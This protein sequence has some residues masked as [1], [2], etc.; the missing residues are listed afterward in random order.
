MGLSHLILNTLEFL[1][2]VLIPLMYRLIFRFG[3]RKYLHLVQYDSLRF[4]ILLLV[5]QGFQRFFLIRSNVMF[6]GIHIFLICIF[7]SIYM[8]LGRCIFLLGLFD[9]MLCQMWL[10]LAFLA[11]SFDMRWFPLMLLGYV[12]ELI[13][14]LIVILQLLCLLL[15]L[16]L[17]NF[18]HVPFCVQ[19]H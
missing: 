3:L 4:L 7:Q 12:M 15:V 9:G 5:F 14:M 2:L 6:R 8:V 17:W 10:C 18:L 13:L 19:L 16:I 11:L 1:L